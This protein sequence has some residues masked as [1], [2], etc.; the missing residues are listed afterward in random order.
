MLW[1]RSTNFLPKVG[2]VPL[3]AAR[4]AIDYA[5]DSIKNRVEVAGEPRSS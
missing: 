5:V 1:R 3:G 2:G 4:A